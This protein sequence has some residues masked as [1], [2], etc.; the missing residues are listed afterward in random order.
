MSRR[1]GFFWVAAT[2]LFAL[3]IGCGQSPPPEPPIAKKEAKVDTMFGHVMTDNYFW[4][5][6]R[7][8]PEVIAYL[9]A[10][11]AY[12]DS[13][14]KHAKKLEDK[15]YNEL[16]SRIIE[17]DKSVPARKGDYYYYYRTEEGK[18]YNIYCRKKGSVD[19]P[20][21]VILDCNKLAEGKDYFNLGSYKVS[22]N[23]NILAYAIDTSGSERYIIR[24]KNL[25]TGEE[26]GD[27]ISDAATSIAWA[28]DNKT[29]FYMTRDEAWRPYQL[30]RHVLGTAQANDKLLYEEV[31]ERFWSGV[32]KSKS[33]KY[34]VLGIESKLTSEYRYLDADNP[35]G[36]L[37]VF[38]K[39]KPGVEYSIS[40]HGDE[41]YILTNADGAT[42][43]KLMK[44]PA[45]RTGIENWE[46][47]VP[48]SDSVMI[49][50]MEMFK[51][52]LVL[53]IRDQGQ[54]LIR[55]TDLR[56]NTTHT[57]E[58][59]EPVYT[60]ENGTNLEY[61]TDI[62][63]FNYTS[64]L[65]PESVYDYN[66]KTQTKELR[67]K[68]KVPGY[69]RS[70]Y[71]Q[72]RV[73]ARASDGTMIP[74]SMCYPKEM[75]Q[76]SSNYCYL[77][78]YGAYGVS[79][80]PYFSTNR[81]SL[82]DRGFIF[83]IAHIR[84]G[85]VMGRKWYEEG[86][87]LNKKNTFTDFIDCAE[88]LKSNG[89]TSTDRL[90]ISGGSAGGLLI[91]AVLNMRPDLCKVA[92]ARVPFVDV[93]NTMLDETIPLTVPEYEEWGNPNDSVYFEYMLSYS[94]YDNVKH[95]AYPNILITA[96]LNDPR[97]QYWEPA[98]WTAK[99]R[100]MKTDDNLLLL[101]INMGAGHG[102]A[103]GRYDALRELA[104]EYTFILDMFGITK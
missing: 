86:K 41:F 40:N 38:Q 99:L 1:L 69:D 44:T 75:K 48:A 15:I 51:N 32:G 81:I 92:V 9:E 103:S 45:S 61:D 18:Q 102:G 30:Y 56:N 43:F 50:G 70:K 37:K 85:G 97:V 26:Y 74:I 31:D 54:T 7:D 95:T 23:A 62:L 16:K 39:R 67:K 46:T 17:D 83:A 77:Y 12:T 49:D 58:F 73:F 76:D 27:A 91:G 98:K 96:G 65:T 14:M 59:D 28:N 53:F 78:G 29:L 63:R 100:E 21:E 5:R 42:N 71:A 10:E 101:Y 19:A 3:I 104:L 79:Y 93:M 89:Y 25:D 64:M 22:P 66:M 24:F 84:G 11:N 52:Y 13:V 88:Y 2:L 6:D 35:T 4:L 60:V 55:V 72:K 20:E 80:D 90:A 87:F 33:G 34:I 36:E 68:K 82:L 47:V 94:P 8:N 57:V